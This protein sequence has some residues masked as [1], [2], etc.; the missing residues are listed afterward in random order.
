MLLEFKPLLIKDSLINYVKLLTFNINGLI[1]S[2]KENVCF[3]SL[4]IQ[5]YFHS[6]LVNMIF[7]S[8]M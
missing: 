2:S 4:L 8:K 7:F 6:S 3:V 1:M 5:Y